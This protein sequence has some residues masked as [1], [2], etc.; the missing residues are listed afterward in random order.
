MSPTCL[1]CANGAAARRAEHLHRVEA[2]K[3]SA[4]A[5]VNT[6][7]EVSKDSQDSARTYKMLLDLRENDHL[8]ESSSQRVLS[9]SAEKWDQRRKFWK[10]REQ[11]L[12]RLRNSRSITFDDSEIVAAIQSAQICGLIRESVLY[13]K[14]QLNSSQ[15]SQQ[16]EPVNGGTRPSHPKETAADGESFLSRLWRKLTT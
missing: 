8:D 14:E 16:R 6:E 5:G 15:V 12:L 2:W 9:E 11:E 1:V 7:I 4:V 10:A 3:A 13:V